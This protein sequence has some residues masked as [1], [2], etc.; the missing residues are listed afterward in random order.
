MTTYLETRKSSYAAQ[1]SASQGAG[2][3]L[4]SHAGEYV[5]SFDCAKH[6]AEVLG[7]RNVGVLKEG[8]V[9]VYRILLAEMHSSLLKLSARFS[10]A[11]VELVAEAKDTRF[12]L[13]W[14]IPANR[15]LPEGGDSSERATNRLSEMDTVERSTVNGAMTVQTSI[16]PSSSS[17]P[18]EPLP[19]TLTLEDF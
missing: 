16:A 11:L 7:T 15:I 6:C 2:I 17:S 9:Q 19:C 10:V 13:V 1:R 5:A 14:K 18:A 8:E 3:T 4:V 12:V